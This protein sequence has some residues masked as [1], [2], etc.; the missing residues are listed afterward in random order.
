L[1]FHYRDGVRSLNNSKFG[2]YADRIY[3]TALEVRDTTYTA[4]FASYVEL[5]LEI[6][7]N[8]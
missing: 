7:S 5:H 1:T 4:R 8:G 3:T 6:D 2:D